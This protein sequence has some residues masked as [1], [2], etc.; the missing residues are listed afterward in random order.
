VI[1]TFIPYS[2][3]RPPDVGE[4]YNRVMELVPNDDDWAC[5][6]DHDA[7]FTRKSWFHQLTAIVKKHPEYDCF[8][9]KTNRVGCPWQ[10]IG[11]LQNSDDIEEHK[12]LGKKMQEEQ[13][14]EVINAPASP[15]FSG[16]LVLV[17]KRTWSK[18]KF[19]FGYDGLAG[20]DNEFHKRLV[21]AGF[22]VGLMLGVYLYHYHRVG[23]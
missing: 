22:R 11:A 23:G 20:V 10:H 6:I 14:D 2:E 1:Y 13:Y 5:I 3:K 21:K 9:A 15:P 19:G 16:F 8:V 12:K 4:A 17:R 18:V 7:M